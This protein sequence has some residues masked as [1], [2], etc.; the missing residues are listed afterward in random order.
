MTKKAHVIGAGLAGLSAAVAL[1]KGGVTVQVSEAAAQGGGRCRSYFDPQ[2]GTVIDNGNHLVM[3]GN[4]AI[5]EYLR[6]IGAE[7][8]LTGPKTAE[9]DFVDLQTQDRWRLRPNP[10]PLPWWVASPA[11]RV[12]GTKTA[13][14]LA[15]GRSGGV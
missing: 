8:R 15:T 10:G 12:P 7:D 2:L 6:I 1:A 13:D 9:F 3:S 4:H 14:Y 11:R 5:Y